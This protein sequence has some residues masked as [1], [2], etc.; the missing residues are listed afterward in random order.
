MSVRW[1][2]DPSVL[3]LVTLLLFGLLGVRYAMYKTLFLEASSYLYNRVGPSVR[4]SV[5]GLVGHAFV[6]NKGNKY[7]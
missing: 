4:W 2:V 7:F 6:K 5:G 3:L 1:S